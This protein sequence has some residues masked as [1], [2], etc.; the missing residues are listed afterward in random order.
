MAKIT[1]DNVGE[2][3]FETGVDHGVLYLPN[4]QGAYVN[5][6]AWNGLT[7]VTE[8]PSGAEAS[9]QYADNI[10]YLNL[11][12]AEEFAATVEAFTWP[13]EF[14]RFDGS[15]EPTP[16]VHVGQQTRKPFGLSY[17]TI[18]GN[19]LEGN[20][21]GY[22]LHLV[23]GCQASPSE[24]A[25]ATV[26]DSPE[27]ITFSWSLTTTPVPVPGHKPSATI[28]IDSTTVDPARLASLEQILYGDTGVDPALPLPATVITLMENAATVVVPLQPAFDAMENEITIPT[29]TG[30][31]YFI[32]DLEVPPGVIVIETDT[33]VVARPE[34]G[35][36]FAS[37][38][39]DDWFYNHT[40]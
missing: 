6:V 5:G 11:Y 31:A 39:D 14:S 4:S 33:I 10:K 40:P 3:V 15:S 37:N 27:A 16:G 23:Y 1:W 35:Y 28:T 25:Y 9:A 24:K 19:D 7:G 36:V 34:D 32:D 30:V 29:V 26:N 38:V 13:K 21:Y 8:S 2:R 20:D 17:R 18:K 12:S 22:K